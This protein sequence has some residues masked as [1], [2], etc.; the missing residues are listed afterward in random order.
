MFFYSSYWI[1]PGSSPRLREM[2]DRDI[3]PGLQPG[4][5]PQ[6]PSNNRRRLE[7]LLRRMLST[8]INFPSSAAFQN[9]TPVQNPHRNIIE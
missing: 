7:I 9:G 1:A 4:V 5:N 2:P 8:D 3:R 6:S